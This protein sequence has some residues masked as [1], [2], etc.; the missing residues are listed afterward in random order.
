ML[1]SYPGIQFASL[2]PTLCPGTTLG[3]PVS[4][5]PCSPPDSHVQYRYPCFV[6]ETEAQRCDSPRLHNDVTCRL[7]IWTK[8]LSQP[9]QSPFCSISAV[10]CP[11]ESSGGT[12]HVE[13][14]AEVFW[15]F[16]PEGFLPDVSDVGEPT[17]SQL[18]GPF[19]V[20]QLSQETVACL[21]GVE[22]PF[23]TETFWA[24]SHD[25]EF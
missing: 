1:I 7:G 16:E 8:G 6:V 25:F 9:T 17:G 13:E 11:W 22:T 18:H 2:S 19:G 15:E 10:R 24:K 21:P 12:L 20:F 3:R 23:Q 5:N 14:A 4:A